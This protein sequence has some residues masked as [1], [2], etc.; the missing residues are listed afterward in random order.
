[1]YSQVKVNREQTNKRYNDTNNKY[2]TR[3]RSYVNSRTNKTST[4]KTGLL[5]KL[6]Q[7]SLTNLNVSSINRK[8]N[9]INRLLSND[10]SNYKQTKKIEH[11]I[12]E[13]KVVSDISPKE[14]DV[15][16]WIFHILFYDLEEYNATRKSFKHEK[17][18]KFMFIDKI[19]KKLSKIDVKS[20]VF[21]TCMKKYKMKPN[22]TINILGNNINT[23]KNDLLFLCYIFGINVCFVKNKMIQYFL[24]N[25]TSGTYYIVD[26]SNKTLTLEPKT[27]INIESNGAYYETSSIDNP[28]KSISSYK[29][30]ELQHLASLFDIS[31]KR[32]TGKNKTKKELYSEILTFI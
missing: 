8:Y 4:F 23:S 12:K 7:F 14:N 32:P 9:S 6:S 17:D 24:F 19:N 2:R 10:K 25:N 3:S 11:I 29:L 21:K 13:T 28:I 31:I 18:L 16:F 22:D 26:I 30:A 1:M 27:K 5:T 20:K 15:F